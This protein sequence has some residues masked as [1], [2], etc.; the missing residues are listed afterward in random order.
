MRHV[1]KTQKAVVVAVILSL[2]FALMGVWIRMMDDSFDTFQQSYLR[3]L[4]AGLIAAVIFRRRLT[5][6]LFASLKANEWVVYVLRAIVAYFFGVTVFTIAI[7]HADLATVSF[8]SSVPTLG[9][10]AFI[11]FRE[12]IPL[13]SIPF[14][15]LAAVGVFFLTGVDVTHI[16]LGVGEI[17]SIIAA[18]GFNIGFLMS[19][20]HKKTRSNYDNTTILLL[21]GWIPV[22]IA[23]LIMQENI[24]PEHVSVT[25]WIG[26]VFAVALNIVGLYA[27]NYV[28]T[29]LKAYVA[30]NILLL[31]GIWS[32]IIGSL[33]FAEPVTSSLIVGG[34]FILGSA[35]AVNQIDRRNE[36]AQVVRN[37]EP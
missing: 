31:E 33:F 18:L 23:S 1:F 7:Q 34:L 12:K 36:V 5:K 4:L 19:R 8:I 15:L 28:F 11:M 17:A 32:L 29:N 22:F 6:N 21:I 24:I 35:I 25:A 3:I 10:L 2:S 14:I 9:L 30:G 37:D 13:M 27:A 26:L 16:Q 20:L